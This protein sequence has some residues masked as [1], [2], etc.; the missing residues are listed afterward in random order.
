M[1]TETVAK[2]AGVP[3]A[4][5]KTLLISELKEAP[6]N[7]RKTFDQ[8][9]LKELAESVKEKGVLTPLLVRPIGG[10][11]YEIVGGA[12]RYRAAKLAGL[13]GVPCQVRVLQDDEALECAVIDNLQRNDVAPLEEAGAYQELLRRGHTVEDLAKRIRKSV[14]YI[15]ARLELQKLSAPVQKALEAGKITPSH[16]QEIATLSDDEDQKKALEAAFVETYD[17]GPDDAIVK[18][19]RNDDVKALVSVRDFKQTVLAL[20]VGSELVEKLEALKLAGHKAFLVTSTYWHRNKQVLSSGRW[21][22]QGASKCKF[23]AKGVL[24]DD[25]ARGQVLDICATTNCPRHFKT[26]S[27]GPT[28]PAKPDPAKEKAAAEKQRKA[29]EAAKLKAEL[30]KAV[31]RETWRQIADKARMVSKRAIAMLVAWELGFTDDDTSHLEEII[32]G[33]KRMNRDKLAEKLAAGSDLQ[34]AKVMYGLL[35]ASAIDPN[36]GNDPI[37]E[38]AD[39]TKELKIDAKSIEK[40]V[41]GK[42]EAEQREAEKLKESAAAALGG[43]K[44]KKLPKKK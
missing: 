17:D 39:V 43:V 18:A 41:R 27:V 4:V 9:A 33:I 15:Y 30:E 22:R 35:V 5:F 38:L 12:R 11:Q 24:V 36:A 21:R 37:M 14:R 42:F 7:P 6:Y 34:L 26:H 3:T 29:E 44:A 1:A 28:T 23:P 20:K 40:A 16:A 8:E 19:K 10:D 32:P 13:K 2:P 25:K 31:K